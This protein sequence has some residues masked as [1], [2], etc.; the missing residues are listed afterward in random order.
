MVAKIRIAKMW[1]LAKEHLTTGKIKKDVV[2]Q[3][4]YRIFCPA[5]GSIVGRTRR[6][7]GNMEFG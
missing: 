4:Q 7:A 6:I 5:L 1:D 3:R 2:S